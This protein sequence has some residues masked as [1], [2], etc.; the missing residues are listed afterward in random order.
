M[1]EIKF[2]A[3]DKLGSKWAY[4]GFGL[5]D[6]VGYNGDYSDSNAGFGCMESESIDVDM[7]NKD[8]YIIEQYTG[9]KDKNGREIYEGDIIQDSTFKDHGSYIMGVEWENEAA[10][11]VLTRK[12]WAFRH[13]FYESS[14]PEDCEIIGN[15]HENP[16]LL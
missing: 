11:F 3:W 2:R 16:E 15:I 6:A 12:G 5:G 8:V 9:L 4:C 14:N 10:S 1:R 7:L 13:Y